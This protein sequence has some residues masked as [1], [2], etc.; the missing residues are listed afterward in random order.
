MNILEAR[1]A[2]KTQAVISPLGNTYEPKTLEMATGL[3]SPKSVFG[4]WTLAKRKPIE[5][6]VNEY[7]A[8][9]NT[10]HLSPGQAAS[11][12]TR[13]VSRTFKVIEVVED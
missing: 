6:W 8:G 5:F 1:E 13:G 7:S 4:T 9:F 3:F 2:N 10:I 11:G 12:A